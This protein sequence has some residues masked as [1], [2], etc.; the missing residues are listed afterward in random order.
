MHQGSLG[1]LMLCPRRRVPKDT[2]ERSCLP[3]V[4]ICT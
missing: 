3:H 4:R 2:R 1:P